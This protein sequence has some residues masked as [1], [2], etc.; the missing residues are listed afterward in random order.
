MDE[1]GN[2]SAPAGLAHEAWT[3]HV[4]LRALDARGEHVALRWMRDGVLHAMSS[5]KLAARSFDLAARLV[6]YGIKVGEPVGLLAPNGPEWIVAR[7]AL[8][9]AG[10]LAVA[11]DDVA[12]NSELATTLAASGSRRVLTAARHVPTLRSLAAQNLE[13]LVI[14]DDPAAPEGARRLRDL[15]PG[16]CDDLPAQAPSS[17]AMLVFTS[18]TTGAPKAFV[19]NYNHVWTNIHALSRDNVIGPGDQVLVALPLHHVY[20]LVVGVLTTLSCGAVVVLAEALAGPAIVEAL[21]LPGVSVVVGVPRLYAAMVSGLEARVRGGGQLLWLAFDS[22]ARLAAWLRAKASIDI[23][24]PLFAALRARMGPDLR[25]LV[26]G[27][28]RLEPEILWRLVGLGFEVRSGY[29]LAETASIFTGNLPGRERL[30]SE[31]Q[32]LAGELRIAEANAEGSGEIQL[33]G[34][35]VFAGYVDNPEANQAA[36]TA[37][38]WFRT[39]DLGCIDAAGYLYVTGRVKD[40]LVLGGGKKIHPEELEKVYGESPYIREIAV[41]ERA[42]ALVA[43]VAPDLAAIRD[44]GEQRIEDAIRVALAARSQT[45]PTYQRLA[46]FALVRDALP[47]TRLGKYRRFLLPDLYERARRGA[48]RPSPA[49]LGAEDQALLAQPLARRIWDV[50]RERYSADAV[51]LDAHLQLDL[52]I[53]SLEWLSLMLVLEQRLGL[54]LGEQDMAQLETVRDVVRLAETAVGKRAEPMSA[55]ATASVDTRW[56]APPGPLLEVIG[57]AVYWLNRL[58]MTICFR[59]TVTGRENLPARGPFVL[60]PNH[61]S[62]LDPPLLGAAL[63]LRQLRS[64]YWGGAASRLFRAPWT[65]PIWRALH[66][67]PV[68]ER[69]PAATLALPSMVLARGD[70]LVWF[71]EMWRSADG[72]VQTFLPGIGKLIADAKVPAVP[73]YIAGSFEALPR[74]RRW[75]RF[76]RIQVLIGPALDPARLIEAGQGA[77]DH[78]RIADAL[79]RQVIALAGAAGKD[80]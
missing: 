52:G 6:R 63:S 62:D 69:R 45:L 25:L 59:L 5:A 27:G 16:Q 35:N 68:D 49:P 26:S 79:R 7:L 66:V 57:A 28:A 19:L 14:D 13:L 24:R 73:V 37:D 53:D 34:P 2:A 48:A 70:G 33:R 56:I 8:G 41:L 47:R 20:P 32:P 60:V 75:P 43:L 80:S 12:P 50:M 51:T 11:F 71:P 3:I 29:G 55:S 46:G 17:P 65:A 54:A 4:L 78:A 76:P 40:M 61:A 58:L 42:G 22:V 31:G 9:A 15:P 67:M 72:R 38:G 74:H 39:G 10:A 44:R 1:G 18:G 23:A 30:E 36:F 77:N 64:I 21:R